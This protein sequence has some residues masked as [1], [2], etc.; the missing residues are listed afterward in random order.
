MPIWGL[1]P[2]LAV[3]WTR[4]KG[5]VYRLIGW[6]TA[7]Q[8][9]DAKK[10]D[11]GGDAPLLEK[12]KSGGDGTG[13]RKRGKFAKR[14]NAPAHGV[15]AL[16]DDAQWQALMD[17]GTP[18]VIDFTATW[19]GPCQRIKPFFHSLAEGDLAGKAS[20]VSADVDDMQDLAM[21][22]G[23]SAMPTFQVWQ[24]GKKLGETLGADECK[25]EALVRQHVA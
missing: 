16:S 9:A 17:G 22:C 8:N 24:S 19:C 10:D 25:L 12:A 7:E 2:F 18:V 6:E 21:S 11:G 13:L 20:F 5:W 1:L 15:T 14:G 4:C 23:V 3:L